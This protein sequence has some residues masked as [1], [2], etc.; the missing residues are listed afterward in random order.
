MMPAATSDDLDD[1]LLR[2]L[3]V[4]LDDDGAKTQPAGPGPSLDDEMAKLLGE[5]ANPRR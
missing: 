1:A 4:S 3:Q 2:E 5:L